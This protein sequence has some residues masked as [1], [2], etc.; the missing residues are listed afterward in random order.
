MRI[1]ELF[2]LKIKRQDNTRT[3]TCIEK[4]SSSPCKNVTNKKHLM[5]MDF[6]KFVSWRHWEQ[7]E[8]RCRQRRTNFGSS[9]RQ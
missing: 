1:K 4:K 6:T 2:F 8:S 3:Q 5:Y 7:K 9:R